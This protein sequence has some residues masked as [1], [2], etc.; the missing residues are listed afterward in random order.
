[1]PHGGDEAEVFQFGPFRLLASERLLLN[2]GE[3]VALGGR[4]LDILIA[5]LER[6]GE[7]V[8][9]TELVKRTWPGVI[10]EES[11]LR[12]H[13]AALRKALGEGRAGARF[14]SNVS[15]RGYCFVEP[16]E[17]S[18]QPGSVAAPA[19]RA[20]RGI[21]PARLERMV[22]RNETVD[23]L[24]SEIISRRFVS[25]VGPGGVGKTTVAVAVAHLMALDFRDSI[26]FV[27]FSSLRDGAL[28]V[29]AAASAIGCLEQ[30]RDSLP[31]LLAFLSDKHMLLVLDSCEHV[32]ESV[33]ALTEQL[34]RETSCVHILAT[35]REALR[36]EGE[37]IRPLKS[38]DTPSE[39][40]ELTAA[41]VL[42]SPAAQLFMNRATAGGYQQELADEE[43]VLVA[44]I[45]RK[46]NGMPLAIELTASRTGTYG[47]GGLA[48]LIGGRLMLLWQGR[49]GVPRHQTLQ[50]MLDWSYDLL[51]E[52]LHAGNG[53]SHSASAGSRRPPGGK[54]Y[55]WPGR[56]VANLCLSDRGR[57][58]ISTPRYHASLR[59]HQ[60][61]GTGRGECN[62]KAARTPL[63]R[64]ARRNSDQRPEES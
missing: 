40:S 23:A 15:G 60:V 44:D 37:N 6:A 46:L 29:S 42:E 4:A 24:R 8:S 30:V 32:V 28:V 11:S 7:V 48:R 57:K 20:E 35:T 50:A 19:E 51:S 62:R 53:E 38:L 16:V 45:C 36:A 31:R 55:Y 59:R 10:V 52:R 1:L 49:R 58:L 41:K 18:R 21:L 9:H 33:A 63:R 34:F 12:V 13:V 54:R 5:L 26:C 64:A 27:D 3:P 25:I 61:A 2:K 14:I 17:R 43:A 56:E 39:S 22:G 47:I